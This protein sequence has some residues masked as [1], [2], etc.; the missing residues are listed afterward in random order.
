MIFS[1]FPFGLAVTISD[2]FSSI[3]DVYLQVITEEPFLT[4]FPQTKNPTIQ[5]TM[6]ALFEARALIGSLMCLD[7]GS[8]FGRGGAVFVGMG[9][10][11]IGRALQ[12]SAWLLGQMMAG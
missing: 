10:M 6:I 3:A 9:F 2:L 5:G 12:A 7:I 8:R 11:V 1:N 4:V